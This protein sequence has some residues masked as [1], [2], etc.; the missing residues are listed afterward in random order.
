MEKDPSFDLDEYVQNLSVD[1]N[2][3]AATLHRRDIETRS[4]GPYKQRRHPAPLAPYESLRPNP[5]AW[6]AMT[7]M[8]SPAMTPMMPPMM[9]PMTSRM[10]IPNPNSS[11][12][13][14]K[15]VSEDTPTIT[16][17]NMADKLAA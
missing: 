12:M 6:P 2:Q 9:P 10:N 7:S 17:T 5:Y 16:G 15:E 8:M 14:K 11:S 1:L 4:N 3:Y 13:L